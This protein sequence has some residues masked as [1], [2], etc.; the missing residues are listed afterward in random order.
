MKRKKLPRRKKNR[1]IQRI[2]ITEQGLGEINFGPAGVLENYRCR[3]APFG[4]IPGRKNDFP[5]YFELPLPNKP[6]SDS[7]R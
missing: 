5:N 7:F 1:I 6:L 4:V 3:T 2:T